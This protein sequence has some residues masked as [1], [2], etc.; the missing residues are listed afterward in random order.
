MSETTREGEAPPEVQ[1]SGKRATWHGDGIYSRPR[2]DRD[3]RPYA[4]FFVRAWIP[5]EKRIRVFK[6]GRTLRSAERLRR[7]IL[8]DPER[9]VEKRR[10][11]SEQTREGLT[12]AQLY[13]SFT[14]GYRGRGGTDYYVNVLRPVAAG[15]GSVRASELTAQAFDAYFRKRRSERTS[16]GRPRAGASTIRKECIAAAKMFKWARQR[17]LVT[18]DPLA[19][20]EKPKEP[21]GAPAR[22]LTFEEEDRLLALLPPLERDVVAWGL[23]SAMRRGEILALTWPRIDRAAGVI[24]VA[25]T[26]TGKLRR[27][28]LDLSDRLEEILGRHPERLPLNRV[29]PK[30][31]KEERVI[32]PVFH[33][34]TGAPLDTDR[35]DGLLEGAMKAAAIPKVRGA[36]W[37]VLRKTWINRFYDAGGLPQREA[38]ICGHSLAVADKHYRDHAGTTR[39]QDAGI[40]NR[41]ATV[42][43]TVARK[44]EIA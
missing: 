4:A 10:R 41:P 28:P 36:L 30:T 1:T 27:V 24:H 25:G 16:D 20:Y 26:K 21:A 39:R 22:A 40:M 34:Q 42:A 15:L 17:G 6:A 18:V 29:N 33:E 13:R 7:R 11:L 12:V 38:D 3:R 23:D 19:D 44:A 37:N 5:S 43:R 8:A 9:A 31:G 14:A 35:L 32:V 2:T